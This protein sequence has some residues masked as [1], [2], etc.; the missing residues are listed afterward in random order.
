MNL[1]TRPALLAEYNRFLGNQL[2]AAGK[3][4]WQIKDWNKFFAAWAILRAKRQN[5]Q[6]IMLQQIRISDWC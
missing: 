6:K 2:D 4:N 3:V 1:E 5:K